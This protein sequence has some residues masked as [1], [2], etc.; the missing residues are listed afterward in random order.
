MLLAHGS[1]GVL[2]SQLIEQLVVPAFRNPA[3]EALDDQ[4]VLALSPAAGGARIAFTT[5]SYVVTPL[6]FPG[7]DIG[8]LA[9]NGTIND[10]AMGGARPLALSLAFILEEGLPL[11]DLRRVIESVRAASARAGVPI[12][13]GD[14][15]V[16][17]RGA[18]DKIFINTSGIGVVPPGVDLSSQRVRPGDAILLSGT[19]GDHGATIMAAREGLQLGGELRSDTAALHELAAAVLDACPDAHAMRDPTRGGLAAV[20]VE[21]ASRRKLGIE[22]DERAIPIADTVRG[23]CELYG[24]DPLLL[25]NEGKLVAFV[26]A[27]AAEAVLARMRAHPLGRD[28][29]AIGRVTGEGP[30]RVSLRTPFGSGRILDLPYSEPLPRIC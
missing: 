8:E 23:A 29:V 2:T 30:G 24:L 6:F 5:D 13:T 1:G 3:L 27:P 21:I 15:K 9:V 12:V 18:G 7:G 10:L 25:A 11:D 4:A 19:I 28:A 26:P 22:I 16:V 17:G 14:T 20:L